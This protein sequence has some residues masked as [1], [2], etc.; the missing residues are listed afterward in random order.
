M[1]T[2]PDGSAGPN[3]PGTADGTIQ[4]QNP[5]Q[6]PTNTGE[7]GNPGSNPIENQPVPH[8]PNQVPGDH[9]QITTP[10]TDTTVNGQP[11]I[12]D[13]TPLTQP[14]SGMPT[15]PTSSASLIDSATQFQ[16]TDHNANPVD[17]SAFDVDGF[18]MFLDTSFNFDSHFSLADPH[19]HGLG[20]G[21]DV[22]IGDGGL[23]LLNVLPDHHH[24]ASG[25]VDPVSMGIVDW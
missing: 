15:D 8:D 5:L 22:G 6:T 9:S 20:V 10:T 21:L 24:D 4:N 23:G 11:T 7:L 18:T 12:A 2:G 14:D 3:V 16:P 1:P 17:F 25:I 13:P 19:S